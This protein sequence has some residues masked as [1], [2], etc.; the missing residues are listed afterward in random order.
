MKPQF[1]IKDAGTRTL[2]SNQKLDVVDRIDS[3]EDGSEGI[4]PNATQ[5]F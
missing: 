2:R 5:L 4:I 1:N 3:N